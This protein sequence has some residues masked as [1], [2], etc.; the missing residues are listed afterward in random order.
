M[1][2]NRYG[3]VPA[4]IPEDLRKRYPWLPNTDKE[5]NLKSVTEFEVKTNIWNFTEISQILHGALNSES[6]GPDGSK[7]KSFFY[8]RNCDLTRMI[9]LCYEKFL[10]IF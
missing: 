1:I 3:Y 4:K 10:R 8:V 7:R 2:G 5:D 6:K 9:F